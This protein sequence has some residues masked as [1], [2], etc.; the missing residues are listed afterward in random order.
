[1]VMRLERYSVL[2]DVRDV[3]FVRWVAEKAGQDA[4]FVVQEKV[5][6]VLASFGC[7]GNE[8]DFRVESDMNMEMGERKCATEAGAGT[9]VMGGSWEELVERYRPRLLRLHAHIRQLFPDVRSVTVYGELFGGLYPHRTVACCKACVPVRTEVYYAPDYEFYA[10]DICVEGV[11]GSA[12]GRWQGRGAGDSAGGDSGNDNGGMSYLSLSVCN[13]LLDG[14]GFCYA[15][16]LFQGSFA[17]CLRYPN[18]FPTHLPEGFGLPPL[19]NN[20][21]AGTVIRPQVPLFTAAGERVLL[22]NDNSR[23][24]D[25]HPTA[26][27]TGLYATS[28]VATNSITHVAH[29]PPSPYMSSVSRECADMLSEMRSLFTPALLDRVLR[30]TNRAHSQKEAARLSALLR[31]EALDEFFHLNLN[32]YDALPARERQHITRSLRQLS[33]HL[34]EN[35]RGENLKTEK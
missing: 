30:K 14:L 25:I 12:K 27:A 33:D 10:F 8:V 7:D 11:R 34:A 20:W 9:E 3:S 31:R 19:R 17:E 16:T 18:C 13:H 26:R 29:E 22:K 21:C 5:R 15:R 1:M 2:K 32:R 6:G 4:R 28:T 24:G 35:I 23:L